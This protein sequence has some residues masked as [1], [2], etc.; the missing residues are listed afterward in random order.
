MPAPSSTLHIICGTG[1]IETNL[2][3][4]GPTIESQ[5]FDKLAPCLDDNSPCNKILSTFTMEVPTHYSDRLC[6]T[7]KSRLSIDT[8]A[9][10]RIQ[11]QMQEQDPFGEYKGRFACYTTHM[12]DVGHVRPLHVSQSQPLLYLGQTPLP[13]AA[14]FSS[15]AFSRRCAPN[16]G[17]TRHVCD[18]L[19]LTHVAI[20]PFL[21][22]TRGYTP[23]PDPD[24]GQLND[25]F[26]GMHT[27]GGCCTDLSLSEYV[28]LSPCLLQ[29]R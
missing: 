15:G 2:G 27:M 1:R 9:G 17:R 29:V 7:T 8:H 16:V 14:P 24:T 19:A 13:P 20:T 21:S 3:G 26:N 25:T 22:R 18:G 5:M 23:P 12:H 11:Q 6:V 4:P 10:C 28:S